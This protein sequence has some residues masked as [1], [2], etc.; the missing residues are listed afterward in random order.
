MPAPGS[1]NSTR[2]LLSAGI[3]VALL[4]GGCGQ[5]GGSS[6]PGK[7]QLTAATLGEQS[8]LATAEYLAASPYAEAD[9]ELGSRQARVCMACHTLD[10]GGVNM[11]GPNLHGMFGRAAGRMPRPQLE[12]R[13]GIG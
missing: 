12:I 11:L 9:L 5:E 8:I 4:L 7:T 13:L 1:I 6:D 2:P 3:V 10:A